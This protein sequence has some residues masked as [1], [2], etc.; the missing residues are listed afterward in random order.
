MVELKN[1]RPESIN[2]IDLKSPRTFTGRVHQTAYQTIQLILSGICGT[3]RAMCNISDRCITLSRLI[4]AE[5]EVNSQKSKSKLKFNGPELRTLRSSSSP[6][7]QKVEDK[8]RGISPLENRIIP[9]PRLIPDPQINI[10]SCGRR[11]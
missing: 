7:N 3:I 5:A 8:S 9:V 2:E 4:R 1:I 10:I 11:T 6:I